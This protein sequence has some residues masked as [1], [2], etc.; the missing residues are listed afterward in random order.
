M[1]PKS[2]SNESKKSTHA[3]LEASKTQIGSLRENLP[4]NLR[5]TG[6]NALL[7]LF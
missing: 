7:H 2:E 4:K 5:T 6:I 1:L 3:V